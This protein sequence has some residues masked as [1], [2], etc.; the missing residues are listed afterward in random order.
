MEQFTVYHAASPLSREQARALLELMEVSF[1]ENERRERSR[2]R[3]LFIHPLYRVATVEEDGQLLGFLSFWTLKGFTFFEHLAVAPAARNRG[4]G[5]RLIDWAQ[6]HL[7]APFVLEVEL[8]EEEMSRRRVGFYQRH[9]LILDGH[10]YEQMPYRAEDRPLPM[11]LMSWPLAL[12][13]DAFLT[14]RREIYR[15][16]YEMPES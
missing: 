5:G 3:L 8:P 16:V 15:Y 10:F 1:P 2:Q 7:P 12:D 9:G 13:D 6:A 4:I 11:R 14:C